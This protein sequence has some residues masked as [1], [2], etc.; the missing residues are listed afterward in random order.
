VTDGLNILM[1]ADDAA[2]TYLKAQTFTDLK[3][4]FKPNIETSLNQVGAQAAW[5]DVT[6]YYNIIS[7]NPVNTD[8][9]DHTTGKALDGLFVLIADEELKIRTDVSYRI[10]DLLQKV[11]A[12]QD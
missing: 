2:T 3:T 12:K 6:Q 4:A 7:S 1:G 10:T 8:L 11:F 9:A 5:N